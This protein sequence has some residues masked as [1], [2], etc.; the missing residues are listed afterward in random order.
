M[1][2][3]RLPPKKSAM[4]RVSMTRDAARA[5]AARWKRVNEFIAAERRALTP[6]QK[7]DQWVQLM[8]WARLIAAPDSRAEEER[9]VRERWIRLRRV[10]RDKT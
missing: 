1:A 4:K 5:W 8:Q 9:Q 3:R 10:F 6:T 2:K 7:F